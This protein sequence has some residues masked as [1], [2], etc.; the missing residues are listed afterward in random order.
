[1]IG[2]PPYNGESKNKGEWIMELMND[3][4]L[5]P[6]GKKKLN[7]KNPKWIN[8]DY[9]KFIR[10]GQYYIDRNK[11]GI[12]AYINPHGFIDNPTFRGVRW[13]LMKSFDRI[14]TIN[15]HGNSKKGETCP[16]G[17]KDENVFDIQQGVSINFFI[18]TGEKG[19][20]EL[21]DVY[22]FDLYGTRKHKTQYLKVH[23]FTDIEFQKLKP[24]APMYFF[25]PKDFELSSEYMKGF[26]INELFVENSVGIV[27][28]KDKFLVCDSKEEVKR[29]IQDL[30]S[31]PESELQ[32]KYGLKDSR[33]WS[34]A[35]AKSDVGKAFKDCHVTSVDYRP[36]D[37][38]FLYYTG[39]TNGIVAWP[40]YDV[41]RH[42]VSVDYRPFDKKFIYYTGTTNGVIARPRFQTMQHLLGSGNIALMT[43]RQV[44]CEQW[45]HIGVT[46]NIMD[47]C[48]VSN[49][50]KERGYIY[51]L[52]RIVDTESSI[53][54]ESEIKLVPNLTPSVVK[55][56]EKAIGRKLSPEEILDYIYAVLHSPMYRKKHQ[57][58]LKTDFPRIPYPINQEL[59]DTL[60]QHGT[61]LRHLHLMTDKRRMQQTGTFNI[62]GSN[63]VEE[64]TYREG[65]VYINKTQCFGE[66]PERAWNFFVGGYQPA[67]KWLKDRKGKALDNEEIDHYLY[68]IRILEDTADE[69]LNID[70]ILFNQ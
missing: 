64:L 67:Q 7:E 57:E 54:E 41:M 30:I 49:K 62:S 47:D 14:Y 70:K 2:N 12:M 33:D 51:P 1:M 4:K 17:S 44:I 9:V 42:I 45:S 31:L 13:Q 24:E 50:T 53:F 43:C 66:I 10:L 58:F 26:A 59:F 18:K 61:R 39:K 15:L 5:E 21:G 37:R 34:I 19:K 63:I 48:R 46:D 27:T 40:R 11:E 69:M 3:Y 23:D 65:S 68:I 22:Y 52:Y 29:R 60:V 6:G 16:D 38:K 56:I 36:F 20:D 32:E 25:T 55:K 8:D 28:T 35:R